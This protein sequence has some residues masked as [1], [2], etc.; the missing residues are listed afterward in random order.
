MEAKKLDKLFALREG[1]LYVGDRV[2]QRIYCSMLNNILQWQGSATVQLLCTLYLPC[3][4][5]LVR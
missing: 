5:S 1:G 4:P 3:T 2:C